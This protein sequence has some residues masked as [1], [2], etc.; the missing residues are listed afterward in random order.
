MFTLKMIDELS[1]DEREVLGLIFMNRDQGHP[2]KTIQS[3]V[4]KGWITEYEGTIPGNP[5]G[6]LIER[7]PLIV[8][9]YD[10]SCPLAHMV[11]CEWC[12]RN[13]PEEDL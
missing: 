9:R 4:K 2:A 1:K 5:N 6:S 13:C 10:A 8:K 11:W 3:L 7:L 12:S